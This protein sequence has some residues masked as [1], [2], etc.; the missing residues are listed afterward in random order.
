MASIAVFTGL[1][2]I[3]RGRAVGQIEIVLEADPRVAA[4]ERGRSDARRFLTPKCTDHPMRKSWYIGCKKW[5]QV[6]GSGPLPSNISTQYI[7]HRKIVEG[8]DAARDHFGQTPHLLRDRR[9]QSAGRSPAS[10]IAAE[11]VER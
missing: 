6:G 8:D 10:A 9:G 2:G 4:D 1:Q 11:L 7:Q 3:F 5:E